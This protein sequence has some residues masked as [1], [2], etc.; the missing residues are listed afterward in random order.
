MPF[1]FINYWPWKVGLFQSLY[2]NAEIGQRGTG[3]KNEIQTIRYTQNLNKM[4]PK[5]LMIFFFLMTHTLFAKI[6]LTD[7]FIIQ[8]DRTSNNCRLN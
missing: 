7:D 2:A 3:K 8:P 6:Y 5:S 4:I 1:G